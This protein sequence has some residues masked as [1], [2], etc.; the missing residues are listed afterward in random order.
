MA[1]AKDIVTGDPVY[2]LELDSSRTK[3]QCGCECPSC[4]LHL[5]A[6][7]AASAIV[8]GMTVVTRNVADF[9]PTGV[10]VINPWE[11]QS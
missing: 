10:A 11:S 7:I 9:K 3:S 1:W 4:D 6:V 5:I 2:I 8:H